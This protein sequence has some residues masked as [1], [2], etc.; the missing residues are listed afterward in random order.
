MDTPPASIPPI[1]VPEEEK[2]E[3]T[4]KSLGDLRQQLETGQGM[5]PPVGDDAISENKNQ[6]MA[7][8]KIQ[9]PNVGD[10]QPE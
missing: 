5:T 8:P 9:T 4:K 7:N 6:P 10:T 1:K 3:E 2:S